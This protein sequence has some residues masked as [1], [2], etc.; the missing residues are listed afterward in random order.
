MP[1]GRQA[2]QQSTGRVIDRSRNQKVSRL[3][4]EWASDKTIVIGPGLAHHKGFNL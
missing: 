3:L 2:K 4:A 1:Y